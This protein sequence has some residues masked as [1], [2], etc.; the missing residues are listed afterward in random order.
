MSLSSALS[1]AISGMTAASRSTDIIAS[2]LANAM[3]EGYRTRELEVTSRWQGTGGGV[4][5]VGVTRHVDQVALQDRRNAD[6]DLARIDTQTGFLGL[7][8]ARIGL[9][10]EPGSLDDRL[11]QLDAAMISAISGPDSESRLG[12]VVER[13]KDVTT[14]L[15]D[16]SDFVQDSR[17]RADAAIAKDVATVNTA[18]QQI[19]DLNGKIRRYTAAGEDVSSLLDQ[20]QQLID[21]MAE[22]IPVRELDRGEGVVALMTPQGAMLLDGKAAQLNFTP[23]TAMDAGLSLAGGQL[24]GISIG[25]TPINLGEA[26]HDLDGGRLAANF[27]IRDEFGPDAQAQLDAVA[28]DLIERFADPALDS[29]LAPGDPGLLTDS[30]GAFDPLTELGL[31]GRIEVNAAVDPAQGGELWRLRDGLQASSAGPIGDA[32]LLTALRDAFQADRVP[33]SGNF[34]GIARSAQSLSSDML[35]SLGGQLQ[36]LEVE[37]SFVTTQHAALLQIELENG[38]DTDQEMQ[39]LLVI[40]QA[41]AANARVIQVIDEM[42]TIL[43]RI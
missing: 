36:S 2:N 33:A 12:E 40:E 26:P 43:S 39:K 9:P 13:L 30:G 11:A 31:A 18:L 17:A 5:I 37:L 23:A 28:R 15:G 4:Q 8:E 35:S 14:H 1:N 32:N 16:L 29:T 38:V 6:A 41:Y 25:D 27:D 42:F 22:I 20:R 10:G 21:S 24:S 34:S 3:T 19:E 7:L